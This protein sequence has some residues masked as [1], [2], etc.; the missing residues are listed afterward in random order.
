MPLTDIDYDFYES[1][2]KQEQ[3]DWLFER[4]ACDKSLFYFILQIGGYS[5]KAG[6][7]SSIVIHKPI[8][9]F[10]QDD[11][12]S[13][14]AVFMPRA[15]LK[16]T[17]LTKWGNFWRYLQNNEARILIPSQKIDLPISFIKFIKKQAV[18][19][20]RLRYLY[21]V[22]H[23]ITKAWRHSNSWGS[24][25]CEFPRKGIY[26]EPT[27]RAIGI[28][29]GAQGG[30]YDYISP[31]DL[32][33]EK[34]MESKLI[35]A[36]AQRWFDNIEE[37]LDNKKDGVVSIAGT[38]WGPGDL[39]NY[40][41]NEYKEYTW[42]IVPALKDSKIQDK[43]NIHYHQD[44]NAE[45][46]ES[47]WPEM[48]PTQDYIDMKANPQKAQVFWSQHM[49]LPEGADVMTKF[50]K[51]WLKYYRWIEKPDGK[52]LH[53]NDDH[54]EF[55]M[56]SFPTYGIIDPGGF[57]EK[58]LSKQASRTAVLVGGQPSGTHK[59][60][61]T[62]A[63]AGRFKEPTKFLDQIFRA[64]QEVK[65][66]LFRQEIFGQQYFILKVIK[67]EAVKR[68]IPLRIVPLESDERKDAKDARIQSLIQPIFNGE[69]YLHESM[70][71]LI[72]ELGD[73]P[74]GFTVDLIDCLAMLY[75]TYMRYGVK[76]DYQEQR[77]TR[78]AYA[79]SLNKTS[80]RVGY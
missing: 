62:H 73:Y 44:P 34:G 53:C 66:L 32:V 42:M 7:D 76:G 11:T 10:W 41:Q 65:P 14:K 29:G 19:N 15:W 56:G 27:F 24:S 71:D 80:S 51:S 79:T 4:E 47:N 8:A 60:F 25:E 61:V 70:K 35:L 3:Q 39:G 54:E 17:D 45:E 12:I 22:L 37:L 16:S 21:P 33:S 40:V 13:R 43:E 63:W 49:N 6:G 52:Y 5:I 55:K 75:T 74:G 20:E 59:K 23:K 50:S 77:T 68:G 67:D 48:W 78:E 18:V 57:S 28:T 36:D 38:H 58:M 46:G 72:S 30:H 9:D 64:H 26:S 31:D 2:P 69:F 1:L